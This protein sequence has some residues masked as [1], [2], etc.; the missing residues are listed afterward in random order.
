MMTL[1]QQSAMTLA[2]AAGGN[3]IITTIVVVI[4]YFMVNA[5]E[6]QIE[7]L[8]FGERTPHW[9]DPV[10]IAAFIAYAAYAEWACAIINTHQR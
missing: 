9:L 1:I 6:V 4:F 8:F 7:T 5:L 3:P 2:Q 10:I